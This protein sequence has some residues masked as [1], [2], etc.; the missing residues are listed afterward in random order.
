MTYWQEQPEPMG[1]SGSSWSDRNDKI[2]LIIPVRIRGGGPSNQTIKFLI[3]GASTTTLVNDITLL[4]PSSVSQVT[5]THNTA[6]QGATVQTTAVGLM[7]RMWQLRD[8]SW[9]PFSLNASFAELLDVN[10]IAECSLDAELHLIAV[11]FEK[12]EL[13]PKG[14]TNSDPSRE[15]PLAR[16][17]DLFYV[18]TADVPVVSDE[19]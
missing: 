2:K 19:T 1:E 12:Q 11:K 3:D 10:V 6:A 8:G 18:H 16:T 5:E 17:G 4:D 9:V 15:I 14:T 13:R 7:S